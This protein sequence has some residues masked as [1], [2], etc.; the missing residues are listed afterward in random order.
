MA[1]FTVDL[2]EEL[3]DGHND[4]PDQSVLGHSEQVWLAHHSQDDVDDDND[5]N[6]GEGNRND[7]IGVRLVLVFDID[8]KDEN[9]TA[10][11]RP[12]ESGAH[13]DGKCY[14]KGIARGGALG[15]MCQ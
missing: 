11:D 7:G 1:K 14:R 13:I 3:S 8:V 2:Y 15:A 10:N 9:T 12:E 5:Q 4:R 6:E